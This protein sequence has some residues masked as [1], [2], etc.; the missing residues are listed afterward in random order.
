[1][2]VN[3][4]MSKNTYLWRMAVKVRLLKETLY[5]HNHSKGKNS[6]VY[7]EKHLKVVIKT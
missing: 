3:K 6:V 4:T 1:M 7:K 5:I 2:L